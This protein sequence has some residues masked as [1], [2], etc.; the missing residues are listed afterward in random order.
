MT[1][2]TEISRPEYPRPQFMREDWI[3]LNGPWTFTFDPGKS[4]MDAGGYLNHSEG[5]DAE[6]SVPFCPKSPLI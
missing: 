2:V 4:G 6:I 5:F 1:Q 3:N